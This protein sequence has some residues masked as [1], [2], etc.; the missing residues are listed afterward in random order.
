MASGDLTPTILS[1][2]SNGKGILVA[3]TVSPGTLLHTPSTTLPNY[4]LVTLY[5]VN[6]HASTVRTLT[7]QWGGVTATDEITVT[8]AAGRGIAVVVDRLPIAGAA[9]P[10]RAYVNTGTDVSVWGRMIEVEA[11]T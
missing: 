10:I 3:A 8:L 9:N 4:E 2:S 11:P 5:A 6:R 7:I 1:A